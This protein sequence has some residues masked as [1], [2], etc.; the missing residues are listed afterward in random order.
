[1]WPDGWPLAVVLLLTGTSGRSAPSRFVTD[2]PIQVHFRLVLARS[3]STCPLPTSSFPS[4]TSEPRVHSAGG[5]HVCVSEGGGGW[6]QKLKHS[7]TIIFNSLSSEHLNLTPCSP[8]SAPP[9][10]VPGVEGRQT[11]SSQ[12]NLPSPHYCTP[13]RHLLH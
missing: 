10:P 13:R 7:R 4:S 3:V 11:A 2:L 6:H 1:M 9:R 8:L 12:H 5:K